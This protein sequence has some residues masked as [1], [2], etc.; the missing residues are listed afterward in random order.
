M[1]A[2]ITIDADT[3]GALDGLDR[4]D[5]RLDNVRRQLLR[6]EGAA[7]GLGAA[8]ITAFASSISAAGAAFDMVSR[9]TDFA[10]ASL[11]AFFESSAEGKAIW[12]QIDMQFKSAL[13]TIGELILGTSDVAEAGELVRD[14]MGDVTAVIRGVGSAM[15]PLISV[16]R[17]G[18]LGVL[19]AVATMFGKAKDEADE[20]AAATARVAAEL[21]GLDQLTSTYE[22]T[23]VESVQG[24]DQ[25]QVLMGVLEDVTGQATDQVLALLE[26]ETGLYD[27]GQ[28]RNAQLRDT[29]DENRRVQAAV[30]GL[31]EQMLEA[32]IATGDLDRGF[33]SL[34]SEVG[35]FGVEV[36][37]VEV[38]NLREQ[39]EG[40]NVVVGGQS[41]P[42][43]QIYNQVLSDLQGVIEGDTEAQNENNAARREG[44][45]LL[46]QQTEAIRELT[47]AQL[48]AKNITREGLEQTQRTEAAIT[49]LRQRQID[50]AIEAYNEARALEEEQQREINAIAERAAQERLA[51]QAEEHRQQQAADAAAQ[52]ARQSIFA[53]VG[54]AM[55]GLIQAEGDAMTRVRK[56]LGQELVARGQAALAQAAIMAATLNPAAAGVAA[57][58]LGA[59]ALGKRFGAG[60]GGMG[61]GRGGGGG[62]RSA[63]VT[64]NITFAGGAAGQDTRAIAAAIGRASRDGVLEGM[65]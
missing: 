12:E 45:D 20:Y 43:F 25:Y 11:Q 24:V 53:S 42:F 62:S 31:R 50:S 26:A 32:L 2:T 29:A 52:A 65:A 22:Q 47:K 58:G 27:Q 35:A 6:T 59:I 5:G 37:R 41:L 13:G 15:E 56:V 10:R 46:G 64:Q 7:Q 38:D 4:I 55:A 40:L 8:R 63:T 39:L 49:D 57:A 18:L 30:G 44:V 19:D 9:A 17:T 14:V 23:L 1:A 16:M 51:I 48:A 33:G 28:I 3:R 60:G 36:A 54:G 34:A 21:R 61:A